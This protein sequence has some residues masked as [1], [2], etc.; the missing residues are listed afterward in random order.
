MADRM[1]RWRSK[2]AV[3]L[4]DGLSSILNEKKATKLCHSQ[5]EEGIKDGLRLKG[6]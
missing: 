2:Y 4:G 1:Y 5:Q 6:E 3:G